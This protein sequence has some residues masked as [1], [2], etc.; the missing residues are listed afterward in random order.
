M[1]KSNPK[2]FRILAVSPSSCGFGFAVF[3][4]IDT[5]VDWGVKSVNGDK[6]AQSV[7]KVQEIVAHYSPHVLVLPDFQA[8]GSR[9]SR[10]I[11]DLGEDLITLAA[12]R[13]LKTKSFSRET[14]RRTFFPNGEGTKFG[15][16]EVVAKRF[17]D[18][19]GFRMPPKRRAWES[20]DSRMTMF[21]AVALALMIRMQNGR[22]AEQGLGNSNLFHGSF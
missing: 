1:S 6:N 10:R 18:E 5:L 20:E 4:G 8:K 2:Q 13:K 9:H 15:I 17:P 16:A 7:A 14:V 3:E 21:D 12:N 22:T 11:Q 19:L